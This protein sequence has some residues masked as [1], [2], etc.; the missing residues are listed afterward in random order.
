MYH[1]NN[2]INLILNIGII[3]Y[4]FVND[5][6]YILLYQNKEG[7]YDLIYNKI[8]N[9]VTIDELVV[10]R[11][12]DVTN[13]LILLEEIDTINDLYDD[14]TFTLIKFIKLPQKYFY[15]KSKDFNYY[16]VIT[17]DKKI[18]RE[19]KWIEFKYSNNLIHKIKIMDITKTLNKIYKKNI[20]YSTLNKI[21]LYK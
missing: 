18:K 5:K 9:D 3:L 11:I 12:Y 4:K 21:K 7:K 13:Y 14:T 19:L 16:E 17:D 20:L 15:L 2:P 1:K 8:I 10:N 6:L